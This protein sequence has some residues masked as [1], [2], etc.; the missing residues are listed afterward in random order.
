[1]KYTTSPIYLIAVL[2]LIF[3]SLLG[4][5]EY[6]TKPTVGEDRRLVLKPAPTAITPRVEFIQIY[7]TETAQK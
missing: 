4:A 2:N 5:G 1:M 3:V 6:D 7:E